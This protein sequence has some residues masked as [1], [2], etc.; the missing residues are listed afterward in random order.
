MHSL[1]LPLLLCSWLVTQKTSFPDLDFHPGT[2]AGCEGKCFA[3]SQTGGPK[4]QGYW[5][6][7]QDH[8]GVGRKALLNRAFIVP[9]GA[10]VIRFSAYAARGQGCAPDDRLDVA[11]LAP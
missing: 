5:V 1:T 2:L 4:Q 11:L 9:A 6:S 7:S 8:G 10:G 3:I